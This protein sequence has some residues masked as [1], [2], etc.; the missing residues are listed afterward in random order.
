MYETMCYGRPLR[1]LRVI[2]KSNR[3]VLAIEIDISLSEAMEVRT[4][5]QLEEIYGLEKPIQ[6]DNVSELS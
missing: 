3:E 2:D 5:E 4:L 6:L 1:T